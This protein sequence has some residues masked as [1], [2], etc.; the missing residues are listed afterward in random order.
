[1]PKYHINVR[2]RFTS[3]YSPRIAE[4]AN[5]SR[6]ESALKQIYSSQSVGISQ[7]NTRSL[8][9]NQSQKQLLEAANQPF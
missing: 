9:T 5:N 3:F 6:P 4:L 7:R 2:L 1:L 8:K